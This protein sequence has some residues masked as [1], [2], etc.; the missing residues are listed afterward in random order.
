M[1]RW[2][3]LLAAPAFAQTLAILPPSIELTGPEAR[4]Q[5]IAEATVGD[6]QEDWTRTAEWSSSDPKIAAVDKDG[7]IRPAGDGEARI[8]AR[9]KGVSATVTVRVKDSHAPF[10]WSFRN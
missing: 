9:A 7:I 2:L 1:R 3:F 10:T 4:Q 6:H 5:L 8:T